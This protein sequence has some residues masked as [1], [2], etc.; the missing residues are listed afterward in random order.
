MKQEKILYF[1]CFSGISGDMAMAALLDLGL[2][3][4]MVLQEISKLALTGYQILV[5]RG[6]RHGISGTDVKVLLHDHPHDHDHHDQE[7]NLAQIAS[8]IKSS[9]LAE[10]VKTTA[11][12][13]FTEIAVAEAK[14]HGVTV[15]EIH[16]HEVGAVDSIVDIVGVAVCLDLI[17]ADR[18]L[19]STL[20]EGSGFVQCRHGL[21]PVPVPAVLEMLSGSGF[22]IRAT[23]V[24]A[25]LITPTGLGILKALAVPVDTLP[26]MEI[27]KTGYGFGKTETGSLNAVRVLLG[28]MT[29]EPMNDP[30]AVLETN[31]DD[32]TGETLGYVM[33]ELLKAGALDVFFTPITMKKSRPGVMLSVLCMEDHA[34]ELTSLILRET[35][36]LGVRLRIT[37]RITLPRELVTVK[38]SYGP[39]RVKLSQSGGSWKAASEYEDCAKLARI[40]GHPLREIDEEA[41]AIAMK[42]IVHG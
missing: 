21:L 27:Q 18:I 16:F 25:E 36:S 7:R 41:K 31:L 12:Q 26:A 20:T 19:C 34:K 3:E 14:V 22:R 24:Q 17:G 4:S 32:C 39:V 13:I 28:T 42:E 1:H 35:T 15:E 11:I 33:E 8:L 5:D 23:E 9:S 2:D 38:T 37:N 30:I 29:E 6:T 10:G 40:S